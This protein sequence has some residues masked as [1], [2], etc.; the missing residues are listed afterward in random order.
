MA[1]SLPDP[2]SIADPQA[3][4]FGFSDNQTLAVW[5]FNLGA[6]QSFAIPGG[7]NVPQAYSLYLDF[8]AGQWEIHQGTALVATGLPLADDRLYTLSRL[9][10]LNDA[11]EEEGS[12][13]TVISGMRVLLEEPAGLDRDGDGIPNKVERALGLD[14]RDAD[15]ALADNDG[16]ELSNL[17]E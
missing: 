11:S 1:G 2:A 4:A 6:W 12:A 9:L 15:D 3:L 13:Q 16:D 14:S 8:D 7:A 5:E 17:A 10:L